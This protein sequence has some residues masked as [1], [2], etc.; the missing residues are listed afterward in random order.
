MQASE[1]AWAHG[2]VVAERFVLHR[3]LGTGGFASVWL[4]ADRAAQDAQV[5]LK[6]LHPRHRR[7]PGVVERFVREARLL[8]Q[9]EHPHIAGARAFHLDESVALIALE[10]VAGRSLRAT[11][12]A[13]A[14]GTGQLGADEIAEIMFPLMDALAYAHASGVVHRDVK[15]AN[16]IITDTWPVIAKLVDFGIAKDLG[17]ALDAQSTR[18][19]WVGSVTYLSPEQ[20]LA[21]P[22]D[23]R[24]D[25]FA[26]GSVLFELATLRR[27]WARG[28]DGRPLLA[29]PGAMLLDGPNDPASV[30]QRILRGPR[31]RLVA[32]RPEL[33]EALGDL[34]ERACAVDPGDRFRDVG[35]MMRAFEAALAGVTADADA[36]FVDEGPLDLRETTEDPSPCAQP[37][38]VL[39]AAPPPARRPPPVPPPTPLP[40]AAP[41]VPTADAA[42]HPPR[43]LRLHALDA[44]S[45]GSA[46]PTAPVH[47]A[48]PRPSPHRRRS[49]GRLPTALG[50][51]VAL[52]A[53]G[54]ALW[55]WFDHDP[56]VLAP[57]L[58][59]L[60]V[61]LL[62]R[63]VLEHTGQRRLRALV[64]AV[65]VDSTP[66]IRWQT[67]EGGERGYHLTATAAAQALAL[68]LP[69]SPPWQCARGPLQARVSWTLPPW[70]VLRSVGPG[71]LVI[72][73]LVARRSATLPPPAAELLRGAERILASCAVR[74]ATLEDQQFS[75]T[76][77]WPGDD[78]VTLVRAAHAA[79]RVFRA[80]A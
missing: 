46:A 57:T 39:P 34:I 75:V 31:P 6:V 74:S 77:E 19:N 28:S 68:Q 50:V 79:V 37:T 30:V 1:G 11:L 36:T 67:V 33:P 53:L 4:A 80:V 21:G 13:R 71:V 22:V 16:V 76:I 38:R 8:G 29:A 44:T 73:D 25:V 55:V 42:P 7:S 12:D 27:M 52:S 18:G 20:I 48:A 56:L 35:E 24:T 2:S 61:G 3:K 60:A 51:A 59:L 10:Y 54:A 26:L 62:V 15:P 5:A 65:L 58:G 66:G 70:S 41:R 23:A 69:L 45:P 64:R 72:A 40:C 43:L 78:V 49:A 32:F 14:A 17:V 9:L 47:A 63:G